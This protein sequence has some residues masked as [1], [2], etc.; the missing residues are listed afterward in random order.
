MVQENMKTSRNY[1]ETILEYNNSF[2]SVVKKKHLLDIGKLF[3]TKEQNS[4]V[5]TAECS[6]PMTNTNTLKNMT[7]T[8]KYSNNGEIL[9]TDACLLATL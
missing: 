1:T 4:Y 9:M 8:Y 2:W 7:S 3:L 6:F 5:H